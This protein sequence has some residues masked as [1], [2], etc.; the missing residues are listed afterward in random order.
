[1]EA[2]AGEDGLSARDVRDNLLAFIVAGHETTALTLA[3]ACYLLGLD[4]QV[5]E[6]AAAEARAV[7]G[8]RTAT[9]EDVADLPYIRQVID[10]T[11]R[12]YPPA[13]FLSRAAAEP[14]MILG[15]DILPGDTVTVPVYAIHRHKALWHEPERFD[16]DR[17]AD[18]KTIPRYAYLPFGDGPRICIGASFALQEAI[19]ILSTVL[20]RFRLR[21]VEGRS[22]IPTLLIT[23]RPEG[24]VWMHVEP[25]S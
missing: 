5:Q 21:M 13:A 10:E 7:L 23:L 6:R 15:T 1:M 19:I 20:A 8:T 16:P 2:R 24:G 11:L 14:D 4:P 25:R 9:A 18:R 22:P 12:L 3:W 17:F